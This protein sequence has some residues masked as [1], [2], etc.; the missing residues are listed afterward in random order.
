MR[1]A[2]FLLIPFMLAACGG[3][4][5]QENSASSEARRILSVAGQGQAVGSPDMAMMSFGVVS[6]GKTAGEAMATNSAA[7]TKLRNRLRELGVAA[8]DMQTSNF[9]LNPKYTPYNSGRPQTREIVGYTVNN[10][11][12]VRL[13]DIDKVGDI[14]D[15]AVSSGA[16]NLNS[17][18][19]G[20]Q[21]QTALE[22]EAK[23]AAVRDAR[24]TAE[25]L[26]EEA[27]VKLGRVMSIS[28]G[29]YRASPQPVA[30]ARMEMADAA[31]PIEAGE[32]AL[33]ANVSMTFEI[34]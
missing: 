30:M 33:S 4:D 1:I 20:F 18:R 6:E 23:Q 17:L 31:P 14:I 12:S 24:A 3:A 11:L 9:S 8:R 26:A 22:A 21:N 15:Q 27:G 32:S 34:K 16:N 29:S 28:V 2:T 7:M 10:Q 13:R 5:A 25:L 19:F